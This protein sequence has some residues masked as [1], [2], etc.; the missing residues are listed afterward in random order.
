MKTDTTC[1][2]GAF[3]RALRSD[4]ESMGVR[5]LTCR[6][7][8]GVGERAGEATLVTS[9]GNERTP[10]RL[11]V[12]CAGGNAIDVAH[13][14]GLAGEYADMHFRGEYWTIEESAAGLV[15]RNVYCVPRQDEFPFLDPHWIVRVDG[16]REIGPNAVP[17]TGPIVYN[18]TVR[19]GP[20][21]ATDLLQSPTWNK[22]RV[23]L[24]MDFVSM[25]MF[26]MWSSLSRN[27]M[28]R[29][30]AQFIPRLKAW[31]LKSRG[32]AGIRSMILDRNGRMSKEAIEIQGQNSFHI[33][34]FNSPGATGAPAYSAYIVQKLGQ[35]GWLDHLKERQ[36]PLGFW[37]WKQAI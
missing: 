37:D 28:L 18:G 17:V 3:T 9:P 14:F 11:V 15:S 12:N 22:L 31:H 19:N 23:W 10:T 25:S 27:E 13:M 2:F 7:V 29:R 33:L 21:W 16:S 26:E 4:A 34:N 24:N 6:E 36:R 35:L 8:V 20:S 1:D 32:T 5:F 30:V